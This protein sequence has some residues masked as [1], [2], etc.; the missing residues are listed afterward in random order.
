MGMVD[1]PE[2]LLQFVQIFLDKYINKQ[3]LR[4]DYM[5]N[6]IYRITTNVNF[7]FENSDL[8]DS[9]IVL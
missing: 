1:P 7:K 3:L 9:R 5:D 2:K 4:S 8:V 6:K